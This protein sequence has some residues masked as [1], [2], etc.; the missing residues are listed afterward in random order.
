MIKDK[1]SLQAAKDRR[2]TWHLKEGGPLNQ[3]V[4]AICVALGIHIRVSI[5][6]AP[7]RLA[8]LIIFWQ[9]ITILTPFKWH[10]ARLWSH[11]KKLIAKIL[12]DLW[13]N[14]LSSPLLSG[15]VQSMFIKE[16][17]FGLI[18]LW[19]LAKSAARRTLPSL[20]TPLVQEND[21]QSQL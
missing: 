3:Q 8:I 13:Q 4:K 20:V 1:L 9:K 7:S 5:G 17:I 14:K 15:Q 21:H 6:W 18:F 16:C 19:D 11:L 10:C 12:E 2:V